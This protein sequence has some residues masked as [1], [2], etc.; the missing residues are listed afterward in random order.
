[1]PTWAIDAHQLVK[2][3]PRRASAEEKTQHN[4]HKKGTL[5]SRFFSRRQPG[6]WFTAVDGVDLQIAAGEIFGLLGPNGAG[7]STTIRML[8]TLLEP[9]SGTARVNGF[10]IFTQPTQ[11]RQSL[12][13]VLTGERS[14]Y[15]K[16]TGRENLEYFA[17]LYHIPPRIARKRIDELLERM[18]IAERADELVEKYSTGMKQR[19]ALS[20]ALLARP[21]ILLLDE[22]TLGLDP[23]AARRVRELIAEL[24]TEG[25]TILLTTHYM[26]EA[27]QLSDRIG[28]IDQGKIIALD[29]P[30]GLKQRIA[31]Q[32]IV[33][34]E[35]S[36]W[37][38]EIQ[39][40][41]LNL[42]QVNNLMAKSA[43]SDS[44][45]AI[46]LQTV[47]SRAILPH[48]IQMINQ[49]GTQLVNL[50]IVRPTLEDVFIHLTG[51]AL[52]D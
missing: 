21:P 18:E 19:I 14:I 34:M 47:N 13:T 32:E 25:H 23:Q 9:T 1:M 33:H 20:K 37:H 10:D 42:P 50:N 49:N 2:K 48:L 30:A 28:I 26:E 4:G 43:G 45:Y 16:L 39:D 27:D 38:D 22:P 29:T 8:C 7:K 11:V 15:W 6:S 35:V 52:R 24:K 31:Q 40:R 3:F 46:S 41:L 5:F 36:G 44:L 12:G 17:A 51:K